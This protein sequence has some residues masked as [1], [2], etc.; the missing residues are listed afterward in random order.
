VL[1][2]RAEIEGRAG[3]LRIEAG[4]IAELGSELAPRAGE[5]VLDAAGGA[6][7]SGLHDHH[8]HLLAAAAARESVACG[9]PAVRDRDALARALARADRALPAGRWLRGVGYH[10]SVA[11]PLDRAAL[12]ALVPGRP[13]RIQHR[14]GE[15]WMLNGAACRALGAPPG[16]PLPPGGQLPQDGRLFRADAWLRERLPP[17]EAP[18]LAPIGAQ[19]ASFGVTGVTDAS[20][21]NGAAELALFAAAIA[22]GELPQRVVLF[23]RP[24]LPESDAPRLARGCVKLRLSDAMLPDF[25]ALVAAIEAAH[26]QQR[27]MALHC[28]SRAQLVLAAAAFAAAGARPG[29]RIEHASLAPPDALPLLAALPLSVV[30]QPGFVATR[31]DAYLRD[32]ARED[33]PHLYRC[34]GLLDAGIPLGGSTDAPFGDPDPWAAMR[35]AVDRTTAAGALL[36]PQEAL[37]PERALALFTSPPEA[38]GA[39]ARRLSPGAPADLCLLDRPWQAARRSL[40]SKHVVATW[41]EGRL[42]AGACLA[43]S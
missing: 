1:I 17:G 24:D 34:R 15:L 36:G 31:G 33:Q 41:C 28:V 3:C 35:A 16:A 18:S 42:V 2:R 10:E 14:S 7:L 13:L 30:T 38:P 5:R 21:E 8:L 29:D 27:G 23:G 37:S 40:E 39:P 9:P 20:P 32:V 6:L 22:R 19:L 12:D 26:A 11:G 4:R 25:D 43:E